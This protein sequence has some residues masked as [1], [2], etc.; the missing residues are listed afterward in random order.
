MPESFAIVIGHETNARGNGTFD[1]VHAQAFEP[2]FP[3]SFFPEAKKM[4]HEKN[5][6]KDPIN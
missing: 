5:T 2:A 6:H 4:N 3:H 1:D